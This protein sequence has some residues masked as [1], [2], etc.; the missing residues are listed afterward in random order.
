MLEDLEES[1]NEIVKQEDIVEIQDDEKNIEIEPT[2][3]SNRF[4][5]KSGKINSK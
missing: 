5:I 1:L 3:P 4:N 2:P